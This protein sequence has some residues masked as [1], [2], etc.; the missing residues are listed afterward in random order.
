MKT[1]LYTI[2]NNVW[3]A[4]KDMQSAID[5]FKAE[6]PTEVVSISRYS[7]KLYYDKDSL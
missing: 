3:V 1:N 4:A 5:T 7:N 6:N 2:N